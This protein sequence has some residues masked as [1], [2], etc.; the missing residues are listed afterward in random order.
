MPEL[1]EVETFVRALRPAVVGRTIIAMHNTWPRHIDRPLP[2][3]LAERI[4]GRRIDAVNRRGKFLLFN[5]T[6]SGALVIHLRMS[7]HLSVVERSEPR[8]KHTHTV[9]IL[10]NDTELRFRDTRKFGR[11]YLVDD[12]QEILYKLGPEPLS[13]DFTPESLAAMLADRKRAIK[14]FLLDQTMIAGIGNIY[15]DEALHYA[16]IHPQRRT[17]SLTPAE[18]KRLHAGIQYVLD[19]GIKREGASISTYVKPDGEMGDMQNEVAVFRRAGQ[20]CPR[21]GATIERIVVGGRSTHFC[22]LCQP[23]KKGDIPKENVSP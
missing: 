3:E 11:V 13:P 20:P 4:A 17:D 21:C 12:P 10:D 23:N 6:P 9:F 19:L 1:P 14:P 8:D 22:P 2:G 5:L 18:I 16:Q 7:G 15:A